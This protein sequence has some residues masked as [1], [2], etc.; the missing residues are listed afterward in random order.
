MAVVY[1]RILQITLSE[2]EG[3]FLQSTIMLDTT[4]KNYLLVIH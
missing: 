3:V 1:R 4:Q 2:C